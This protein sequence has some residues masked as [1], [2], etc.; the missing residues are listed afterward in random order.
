MCQIMKEETF[1][2]YNGK[3]GPI[4]AAR[5]IPLTCYIRQLDFRAKLV[6]PA[7]AILLSLSIYAHIMICRLSRWCH[8]TI[9]RVGITCKKILL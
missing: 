4:F 8:G 3:T 1:D 5:N 6:I 7:R 9:L 2:I